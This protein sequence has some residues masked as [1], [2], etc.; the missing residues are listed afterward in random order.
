[1]KNQ[2]MNLFASYSFYYFPGY[3]YGADCFCCNRRSKG[4]RKRNEN[5]EPVFAIAADTGFFI[6]TEKGENNHDHYLKERRQ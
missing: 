4:L 6:L 5:V 1:M 2:M 3:Y